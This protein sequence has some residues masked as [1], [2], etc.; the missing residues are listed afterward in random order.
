MVVATS[1][2]QAEEGT[3]E[4]PIEGMVQLGA[5]ATLPM[6]AVTPMADVPQPGVTAMPQEKMA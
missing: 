5:V 4:V 1:M 3:R 6:E 2:E